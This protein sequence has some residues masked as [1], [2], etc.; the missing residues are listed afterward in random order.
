MPW[1]HQKLRS[2]LGTRC[3]STSKH[4]RIHEKRLQ[5]AL[6]GLV[7]RMM[8]EIL[9]QLIGSLPQYLQTFLHPRWCRISS[10]NS[11]AM[12]KLQTSQEPYE[13]NGG[14]TEWFFQN[15]HFN[16]TTPYNFWFKIKQTINFQPFPSHFHPHFIYHCANY[17]FWGDQTMQMYG[18]FE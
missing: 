8:E 13:I 10:I 15:Q 18:E 3:G 4:V 12:W 16:Q 7:L 17:P 5:C 6:F 14:H 1:I 9:H 2:N 11:I